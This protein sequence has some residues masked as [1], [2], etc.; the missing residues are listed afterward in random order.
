MPYSIVLRTHAWNTFIFVFSI[1]F[2]FSHDMTADALPI[3]P[4]SSSSRD[5]FLDSQPK[6]GELA[7]CFQTV[8]ID[9]DVGCNA[10]VLGYD[11]GFLRAD[12]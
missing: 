10:C 5:R 8:I 1:S 4:F 6:V 9:V 7:D 2:L 11:V 3:L 12:G